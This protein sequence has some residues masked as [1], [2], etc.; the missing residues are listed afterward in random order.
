MNDV[1]IRSLPL[2][3]IDNWFNYIMESIEWNAIIRM[4]ASKMYNY[5]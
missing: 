1:S 2:I 5:N 3:L 4:T